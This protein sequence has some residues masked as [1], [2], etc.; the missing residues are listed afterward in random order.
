MLGNNI[1]NPWH[2]SYWFARML[3]STDQYGSIG[4]DNKTIKHIATALQLIQTQSKHLSEKEILAL[5][6]RAL[7]NFLNERYF[8]AKKRLH[9]I[10]RLLADLD[11][12]IITKLDMNV[13]ILTCEHIMLPINQAISNIP[14]SDKE[15][16]LTIA[17]SFLDTKGMAGLASVIKL[18]D[19]LGVKGCLTAER[20]EVTK[21]FSV[22]RTLLESQNLT[23]V[24]KDIVLTAFAQEFERRAGQKRK[25]R[26]GGS[27]E[28]VTSFILDYFNIPTT[29]S[30]SHFQAD[31]EVDKWIKTSDNWLIGISCKRT[32]RERWKQ[33]SS[34][35]A[36]ILSKFKIKQVYHIITYDEDL[37]DE[38]LTLLGSQRHV[39]YLPDDSTR[40]KHAINHIGLKEYVRPISELINDIKLGLEKWS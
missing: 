20:V 18:W 35:D 13:F 1:D 28:E 22:I 30:P 36:S 10:G 17:K 2:N 3:I 27:L 38:K 11:E 23:N 21:A 4:K 34:A 32:L 9:K 24:D 14:S 29:H 16:A 15:F 26:A 5:Q 8:R 31:I 25:S 40:L 37:S 39:F 33:V 19:T 12:I 6:K 7:S